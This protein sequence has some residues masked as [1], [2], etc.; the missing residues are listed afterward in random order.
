MSSL[1]GAP[2]TQDYANI[3]L[4]FVAFLAT[5]MVGKIAVNAILESRKEHFEKK[6][7]PPAAVKAKET[8][9]EGVLKLAFTGFS[10]YQMS[11]DLP[12]VLTEAQKL[13]GT[14]P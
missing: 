2:T 8:T 9:L 6:G 5:F 12:E 11:K 3:G 14:K 4:G 7:Q 10:L 13:L 1:R